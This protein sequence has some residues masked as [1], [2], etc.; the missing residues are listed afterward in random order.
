[1][2]KP[3]RLEAKAALE[4]F[5]FAVESLIKALYPRMDP[6][7]AAAKALLIQQAILK[8]VTEE[9]TEKDSPQKAS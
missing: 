8:H 6:R 3:T 1:M 9:A 2:A 7:R 5:R 4:L